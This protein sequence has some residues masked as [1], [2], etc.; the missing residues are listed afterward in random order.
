MTREYHE[1][2]IG[3]WVTFHTKYGYRIGII[4]YIMLGEKGLRPTRARITVRNINTTSKQYTRPLY[5]LKPV[6]L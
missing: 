6:E 5:K 1:F 3:E 4:D 2:R